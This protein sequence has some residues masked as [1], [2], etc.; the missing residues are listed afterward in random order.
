MLPLICSQSHIKILFGLL[1]SFSEQLCCTCTVVLAREQIHR[2]PH[3]K[4]FLFW[5]DSCGALWQRT[6]MDEFQGWEPPI[7]TECI[8]GRLMRC[9][10]RGDHVT[11][12]SGPGACYRYSQK[13][14]CLS[15]CWLHQL[16]GSEGCSHGQQQCFPPGVWAGARDSSCNPW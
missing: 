11:P 7:Y 10:W 3:W 15:T 9:W 5:Q 8:W 1:I 6:E 12:L 4:Y 2:K 16:G 13:Q 14:S